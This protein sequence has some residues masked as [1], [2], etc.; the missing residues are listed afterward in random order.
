MSRTYKI[1]P[2]ERKFYLMHVRGHKSARSRTVS[3][4]KREHLTATAFR[5]V[6][7]IKY[8][9]QILIL[10]EADCPEVEI[11]E[12][13]PPGQALTRKPWKPQVMAWDSKCSD[14]FRSEVRDSCNYPIVLRI[15]ES[16]EGE[17]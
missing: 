4:K 1:S 9:L 3:K 12:A 10:C 7:P 13:N 8:D 5:K 11:A 15:S 16:F 17:H 6:T 14:K 2:S